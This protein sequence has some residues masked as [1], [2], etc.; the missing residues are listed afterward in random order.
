[1]TRAR[2]VKPNQCPLAARYEAGIFALSTS[3]LTACVTSA[4]AASVKRPISTVK[5]KSA[6]LFAPS[7]L[8]RSTKP[9]LAYTLL[10]LIPVSLV[11]ASNNGLIKNG[12]RYEYTLMS[13]ARARFELISKAARA[14]ATA[15]FDTIL[16]ISNHSS[17][18]TGVTE[19]IIIIIFDWISK[20]I[21]I[22][23]ST[24]NNNHAQSSPLPNAISA[25]V[26]QSFEPPWHLFF[27]TNGPFYTSTTS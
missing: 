6:G 2:V 24:V 14:P 12:W 1:M 16:F 5:I 8:S 13:A 17:Y 3:L 11:K 10:T 22:F 15:I 7:L 4:L 25:W 23:S 21:R 18:L 19:M 26:C 27:L 20:I 9:F